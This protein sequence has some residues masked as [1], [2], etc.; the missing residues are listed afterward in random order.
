MP[1][2]P[3]RFCP[4]NY[5]YA[6]TTFSRNA[7]LAAETVYVIGGLYGNL[8]ALAE[9]LAMAAREV[10]APTLVFNGDFHWFDTDAPTFAAINTEVLKHI[11]L[12]GNVE[13]ELAPD[14]DEAGCGCAYP[15]Y[16]DDADV[17]RSNSIMQTLRATAR[18]FP[19]DV[20][21]LIALPMHLVIS[22]GESRVGIVHG[23]AESLSGWR[24]AHDSLHETVNQQWLTELCEQ[25][26][27]VG[28]ASSHTCLPTFRRFGKG[29]A[30]KFVVNNGAAGMPN[31]GG[32]QYGLITRLSLHE[33]ADGTSQYGGKTGDL[34]VDALPV[35]FDHGKM[36][37]RFLADWPAGSAAHTS[38]WRRITE[39]PGYA[40]PHA[41]GLVRAPS[42]C[43]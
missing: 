39:G 9:I 43:A 42:V 15:D 17:E 40:P 38:Y 19:E 16:V 2:T 31:F 41:L 1:M 25:A 13:T 22:V 26:N 5:R 3:G 8:P 7:D 10:V 34:F 18:Q 30:A 37:S 23:D 29:A 6:P 20:A 35:H 33:A 27:L 24:F 36:V 11:A 21:R 4:L 12:R 32:T 14:A 28:F